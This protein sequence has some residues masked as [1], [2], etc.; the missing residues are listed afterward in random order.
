V[1]SIPEETLEEFND[2]D[3]GVIGEGEY[4]APEIIACQK[5]G[6]N[7]SEIPGNCIP[8]WRE[9]CFVSPTTTHRKP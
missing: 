5:N 2:F 6:G 3:I 1:S 9:N 4:T 7:I 8:R